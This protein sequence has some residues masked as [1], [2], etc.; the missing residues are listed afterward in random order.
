VTHV[1]DTTLGS[2]GAVPGF[3]ARLKE[4]VLGTL[5]VCVIRLISC[6]WRWRLV[7]E[8]ETENFWAGP[9]PRIFVSWHGRQLMSGALIRYC[10]QRTSARARMV[11]LISRH[12]DGRI[13]AR[14]MK[15]FGLD[16]VAGSSSRGAVEASRK[17]IEVLKSGA[18]IALTPDGP[19]GPN[20]KSKEGVIR[21]AQLCGATIYPMSG[22]SSAH[23]RF[24]SW[25]KMM[26]PKFFAT[27]HGI[28]GP[29][30]TVP[31]RLTAEEVQI[32]TQKLDDLLNQATKKV[33]DA[34]GVPFIL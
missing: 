33:D 1:Q 25:D 24:K 20:Q 28:R 3:G 18:D 27:V 12:S 21:I 34:S 6:T 30:L 7:G 14:I 26:L 16:S 32:Y 17:L 11:A 29:G 13:A 8:L 19:R 31:R 23:W 4:L 2:A 5:G 15:F 22:S 10:D 9:G